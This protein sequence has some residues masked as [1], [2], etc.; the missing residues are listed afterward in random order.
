M[1]TPQ[2][3]QMGKL[4]AEKIAQKMMDS[5]NLTNSQQSKIYSINMDLLQQKSEARKDL[6]N[7]NNLT[8]IIQNIENKRDSLYKQVLPDQ[9]YRTYLQKKQSLISND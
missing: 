9:K 1:V 6:K 4:F 2:N 7:S 8:R 5:L 3:N